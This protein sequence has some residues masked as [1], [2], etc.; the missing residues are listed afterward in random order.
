MR[1][2]G[3]AFELS[4]PWGDVIPDR[5]SLGMLIA[6]F[7]ELHRRRFSYANPDDAVEIV[8]LR[9]SAIGAMARREHAREK[10]GTGGAPLPRRRVFISGKWREIPVMRGGDLAA[11]IAGPAIVEEE[12]TTIFIAEGWRCGPGAGGALIATQ[13][14]EG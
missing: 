7:H 10:R 14:R 1:Y 8:T 5:T 13:D 4:V 12:Y 2:H 9:L 3:Q 11:E 6:R